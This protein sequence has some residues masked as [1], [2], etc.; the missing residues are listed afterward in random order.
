MPEVACLGQTGGAVW[1]LAESSSRQPSVATTFCN[2]ASTEVHSHSPVPSFPRPVRLDGSG[3][4]W[5]SPVCFRTPRCR[6]ACAGW[7]PTWALVG[8]V[9]TRHRPLIW[10]DFVSHA[11]YI[12]LAPSRPETGAGI[13]PP[14]RP[15][16]ALGLP[17]RQLI[18]LRPG[19][20]LFPLP[21]YGGTLSLGSA[22]ALGSLGACHPRPVSEDSADGRPAV[23]G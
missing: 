6:G 23:Y 21:F 18:A 17:S 11:L 8:A 15:F 4:P 12:I 10:S 19:L 16:P 22:S 5:A 13:R 3:L 20:G 7:E 2:A 14:N 9:V 1:F